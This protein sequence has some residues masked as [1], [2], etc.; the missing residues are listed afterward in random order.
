MCSETASAPGAI[1]APPPPPPAPPTLE[2]PANDSASS[3]G[4]I[5]APAGEPSATFLLAPEGVTSGDGRRFEPDTTTWRDD[6]PMTAN[7]G[8][9]ESG[10]G[11]DGALLV[12]RWT[13]LRRT[14]G[15]IYADAIFDEGSEAGIEAK[16]LV[17]EGFL[18]GVSVDAEPG[19]IITDGD[20]TTFIGAR[21]IGATLVPHP[22]FEQSG[23]VASATD[24]AF[25]RP[26][27]SVLTPMTIVGDEIY[28]H[29]AGWDSCHIGLPGCAKPFR[30]ATGYS[31]FLRAPN[32][33]T[34]AKGPVT[35]GGDHAS[36]R[37]GLGEARDHYAATSLAVADVV[38]HDGRLGPFAS[39]RLR[40][41]ITD[42]QRAALQGSA[43]SGDWRRVPE[44]M[45][46]IAVHAVN[47]PGYPIFRSRVASG[48]PMA[49]I[50]SVDPD[51]GQIS[52]AD[53][54]RLIEARLLLADL[55]S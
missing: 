29:L 33:D 23:R 27:P 14:D 8:I 13:N 3:V 48:A 26:E 50:A 16:R 19:E 39:G 47:T 36:I 54:V 11:H 46:L 41:S 5:D 12:G 17:D 43:W 2:A 44:G 6:M 49:L 30:S 32:D 18:T 53:R 34:L 10:F 28:G 40:A 31:Y 22:A 4:S 55:A 51:C 21:L 42:A 7:F 25:S 38:I 24:E 37:A 20:V 45:E 52:L 9:P 1:L 15:S 35:L